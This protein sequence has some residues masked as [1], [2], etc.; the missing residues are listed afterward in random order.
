MTRRGSPR[1]LSDATAA[2]RRAASAGAPGSFSDSP[3][4]A[5]DRD[6]GAVA[7][8]PT[9]A[10]EASAAGPHERGRLVIAVL[11]RDES[12]HATDR[13]RQLDTKFVKLRERTGLLPFGGDDVL[14]VSTSDEN[15]GDVLRGLAAGVEP[16]AAPE[17]ASLRGHALV[18][19][20]LERWSE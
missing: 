9:P 4:S 8:A 12:K 16:D 11:R 14:L 15:V 20:T 18:L 5:A 3:T 2:E 19:Q 17:T 13:L 6:A 7:P 10:P 1:A